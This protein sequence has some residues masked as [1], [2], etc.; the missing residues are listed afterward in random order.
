MEIERSRERLARDVRGLRYEL[1]IPA[2]I[3]RSFQQQTTLWVVSAVVIGA[4]VVALPRLRKKVYVQVDGNGKA[5]HKL[6]QTGFLLGAARIAAT[7]LKPAI[8][9]FVRSRMSGSS[10]FSGTSRRP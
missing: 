4:V 9:S 6:L 5:K 1:D 10:P 3:R 7:L 8:L 2:K